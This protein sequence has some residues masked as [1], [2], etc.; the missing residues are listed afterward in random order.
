MVRIWIEHRPGFIRPVRENDPTAWHLRAVDLKAA[1]G[2]NLFPFQHQALLGEKIDDFLNAP[3]MV[4]DAG[5][6]A[7]RYR[8]PER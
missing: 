3:D 5:S 8:P 7:R 2:F 1:V 4:A 6:H